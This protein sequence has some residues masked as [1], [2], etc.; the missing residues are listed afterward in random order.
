MKKT[1]TKPSPRTPPVRDR[2]RKGTGVAAAPKVAKVPVKDNVPKPKEP[3]PKSKVIVSDSLTYRKSVVNTK[4]IRT[5]SRKAAAALPIPPRKRGRVSQFPPLSKSLEK[6]IA[7]RLR[8][9]GQWRKTGGQGI[10]T[11]VRELQARGEQ[12]ITAHRVRQIQSREGIEPRPKGGARELRIEK[13]FPERAE[14]IVRWAKEGRSPN[15]ISQELDRT[16]PDDAT[17]PTTVRSICRRAGVNWKDYSI[18]L[19]PDPNP[20]TGAVVDEEI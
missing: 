6:E 10:G 15:W 9:T 20:V 1:K 12:G 2:K 18:K 14:K 17:D 16:S 5:T 13:R 7:H 8:G 3:K 11:V 19:A 4:S